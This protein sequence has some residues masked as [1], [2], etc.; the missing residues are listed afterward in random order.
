M[1]TPHRPNRRAAFGRMKLKFKVPLQI[2]IPTVIIT[3]AVSLFGYWQGATALERQRALAFASLLAEKSLALNEWFDGIERDITVLADSAATQAAVVEFSAGWAELGADAQAQLQELYI[4]ANPNPT[5]NKDALDDARD[6]SG[7]TATHLAYHPGFRSFQRNRAYYDLFLFDLQ[8]N[9]VYSVFKE[10]D[11]ATNFTN[12][13]YAPSGLGAAFRGAR[14]LDHGAFVY[15]G[16]APYAPSAD[17]P[18]NF[19]AAPVFDRQGNRI[20]V[21]ALQI[22]IDRPVQILSNSK[23]LG[24]TGE[25]YAVDS[26]GRA[27][28]A[29]RHDGGH[30]VLQQLPAL[31]HIVAAQQGEA[32]MRGVIGLSGQPVVTEALSFDRAGESW[33]LIVEQDETEALA[34][35]RDLLLTTILQ[36]IVVMV[37]VVALSFLVARLFTNRIRLLSGSVE[38]IKAGDFRSDV[39]QI[40]TGDE[41][42][43]IARSLQ[44]FKADLEAGKRVE[45]EMAQRAAQQAQVVKRLQQGLQRLAKG[46]LGSRIDQPFSADYEPLRADFNATVA[47][48][49]DIITELRASASAIDLDARQLTDGAD[50]LSTRTENQAATLEETA[51]AMEEISHSVHSTARS[52][53]E[54]VAAIGAARNQAEHGEDVR[55]QAVQAMGEIETS[56]AQ[57]GSIIQVIEDLAFQTNLLS[58]NAGVEA[59]R[60]GEVGRGFAVVASEVR[61]LAQRSSESAAEIRALVANSNRNVENGVRLVSDLGAATQ[62]ILQEVVSV[63]DRVADIA[64]STKEQ[65]QGIGEIN[66]GIAALD[67]VTQRNAAMVNESASAGRALLDKAA[68]LRGLVSRFH[69]GGRTIDTIAGRT[70]AVGDRAA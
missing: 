22:N 42:G 65:A 3:L 31:D 49:S 41:V 27:L 16:F 61:A 8:G 10:L 69:D 46:D 5:G 17:A 26:D 13:I 55:S 38:R 44:L 53:E 6:G 48:L 62:G 12:G 70:G 25:I 34:A 50:A 66:N 15:S 51:A 68:R 59:A 18:A 1:S 20:G 33:H 4:H 35:A 52:V 40:R 43:D 7:W 2:A 19:I 11:F 14:D 21:A 45:E 23:V 63:S 30:K 60:A 9:I 28:S 37:L 54:I 24:Q 36:T 56:S 57:I 64:A 58:L 67:Q 39:S 47:D 29:S 32:H